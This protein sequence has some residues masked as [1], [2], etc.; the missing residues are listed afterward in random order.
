MIMDHMPHLALSTAHA[1]LCKSLLQSH[2]MGP[3]ARLSHQLGSSGASIWTQTVH[4]S[5]PVSK[6]FAILPSWSGLSTVQGA[7][8]NV[9]RFQ[10]LLGKHPLFWFCIYQIAFRYNLASA[11]RT[12][13][14]VLWVVWELFLLLENDHHKMM[15]W[16][17][18]ACLSLLAIQ[19]QEP[20]ALGL[21]TP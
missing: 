5:A 6:H 10:A 19:L 3:A 15:S 1:S 4:S 8:F 20:H 21:S 7:G 18:S 12:T 16:Q 13:G 2:E 11:I 9:P 14:R 17:F